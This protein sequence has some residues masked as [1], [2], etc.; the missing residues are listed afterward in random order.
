MD[1]AHESLILRRALF[2]KEVTYPARPLESKIQD[3]KTKA[4]LLIVEDMVSYVKH[5]LHSI[6]LT[7]AIQVNVYSASLYVQ[8]YFLFICRIKP[9]SKA[10][11]PSLS[12]C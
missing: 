12:D 8:V 11:L 1:N 6:L 3:F 4:S 7:A 5:Q 10:H 2:F 9:S